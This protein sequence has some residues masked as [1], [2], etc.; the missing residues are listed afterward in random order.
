M[1]DHARAGKADQCA[2]LGDLNVPQHG[3]GRGDPA[4][5]GIRQHHDVGL[6]RLAQHLHG[7]RG[8]RHLH[9]RQDTF[10][11]ARAARSREHDER[12]FFFNRKC[13]PAHDRFAG[14]HAKRAAHEVEILHRDHHRGAFELTVADLDRVIQPGAGARVLDTVGVAAFIPE[15]QRI[16]GDLGQRDVEPGFVIEDRFQPRRR[17]HAH[18]VVGA[19][20]HELV[21]LD[22]LVEY[23]LP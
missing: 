19:G 12:R 3:V 5:R 16:G 2:G 18:V 22:V 11:H 13:K 6:L 23:E 4:S 20:D 7:S 17:A 10:L 8:A 15:F 9:Q 21:G 1:F 14:R